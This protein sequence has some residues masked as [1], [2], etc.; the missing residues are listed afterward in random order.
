MNNKKLILAAV[1]LVAIVAI[2]AGVYLATQ[3][4]PAAAGAKAITVTVI[5]ADGTEKVFT[6]NTDAEKLGTYLEEQGLI[7]SKGADAGMF[8]TVDGEK[9]DWNV[10]QSY[11][12]FYEGEN[13]ATVG[14]YDAVITDGAVYKLVYTIG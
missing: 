6:Y 5:H 12:A 10:N 13:Y 2:L 8:H 11:W 3:S 7:D 9:A 14:I 4:G 1:A